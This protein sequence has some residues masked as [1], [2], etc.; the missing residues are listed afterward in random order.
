MLGCTPHFATPRMRCSQ[1]LAHCRQTFGVSH[2]VQLNFRS[3]ACLNCGTIFPHNTCGGR[4]G[5]AWLSM[6][7]PGTKHTL[8]LTFPLLPTAAPLPNAWFVP[9][10][11]LHPCI[12]PRPVGPALAPTTEAWMAST[13]PASAPTKTAG[14]GGAPVQDEPE[15]E[16]DKQIPIPA[17]LHAVTNMICVNFKGSFELADTRTEHIR[18]KSQRL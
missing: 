7:W 2:K 11:L 10:T 9:T 16:V 6:S 13:M 18:W 5:R 3:A 4:R 8:S 14:A 1:I 15:E 12:T 17:S